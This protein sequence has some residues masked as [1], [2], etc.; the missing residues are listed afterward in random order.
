MVNSLWPSDTILRHRSGST[1]A[2]VIACCLTAPSHYLNQCLP[3]MSK[4]LWLSPE[5]NIRGKCWR[6]PSIKLVLKLGV[7]NSSLPQDDELIGNLVWQCWPQPWGL[8]LFLQYRSYHGI[9]K[10]IKPVLSDGIE[11]CRSDS[12]WDLQQWYSIQCYDLVYQYITQYEL[13]F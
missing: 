13:N 4:V 7:W 12:V 3:I 8:Y 6:Y 10:V 5:G 1:L 9:G 2:L 11:N